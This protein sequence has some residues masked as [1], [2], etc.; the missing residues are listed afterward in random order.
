MTK[1]EESVTFSRSRSRSP[2]LPLS[3]G[4]RFL[5]GL[6]QDCSSDCKF[7]VVEREKAS[8]GKRER[9]ERQKGKTKLQQPKR[10]VRARTGDGDRGEKRCVVRENTAAGI[11]D[12]AN[13]RI[14]I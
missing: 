10:P 3:L 9:A 14:G 2:S 4:G 11:G 13:R 6:L 7:P 8:K 12:T 5:D 1:R